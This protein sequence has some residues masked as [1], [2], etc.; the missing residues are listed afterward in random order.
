MG[1]FINWNALVNNNW[2]KLPLLLM[3]N[4]DHLNGD[5]VIPY[6]CG[7]YIAIFIILLLVNVVWIS[8][9][10]PSIEGQSVWPRAHSK[11][12]VRYSLFILF[13]RFFQ[14]LFL[15]ATPTYGPYDGPSIN[16]LAETNNVGKYVR[17][18]LRTLLTYDT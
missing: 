13:F 15:S 9:R 1:L 18:S 14:A 10:I 7:M 6:I 5:N 11:N 12:M 3:F 2:D 17:N 4:W 16:G 8:L